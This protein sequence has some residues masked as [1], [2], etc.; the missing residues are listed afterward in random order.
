[1]Y[2][3][4]AMRQAV[5]NCDKNIEVFEQAIQKERETIKEYQNIIRTLEK[6]AIDGAPPKVLR[7][8]ASKLKG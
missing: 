1:V 4:E 6:E 5:K 2:D 3:L 8:D 7:I